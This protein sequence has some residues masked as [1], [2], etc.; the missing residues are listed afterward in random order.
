MPRTNF[1]RHNA[2][3]VTPVWPKDKI[4]KK[5]ENV[6]VS[7]IDY[8]PSLFLLS[9]LLAVQG[10]FVALVLATRMRSVTGPG[11]PALLGASAITLGVSIWGMHF[12]GMLALRMPAPAH[13]LPDPTLLSFVVAILAVA[14]AI[15]LV[16]NHP[17]SPAAFLL[18]AL[19]MG[20]GIV[21][22]HFI[23]MSALSAEFILSYSPV[24]VIASSV[25]GF[26]ASG[27][28]LHLALRTGSARRPPVI[29]AI[30]IGVAISG[31]HY[32]AMEGTMMTLCVPP[33]A[34]GAGLP[35]GDF[36]L[37]VSM[38]AIAISL[39]FLLALNPEGS[40]ETPASVPL[41]FSWA[42]AGSAALQG[43]LPATLFPVAAP[44]WAEPERNGVETVAHRAEEA[45]PAPLLGED[46]PPRRLPHALRA[47]RQ[48]RTVYVEVSTLC[49][50][51]ANGH[52]SML[53]SA[54]G[55]TLCQLSIS[56][57]EAK[58]DPK[59]FIRV[60]RSHL[61]ALDAVTSIERVGDGG[62]AWLAGAGKPVPVSRSR[63]PALR[64]S[65]AAWAEGQEG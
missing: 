29:P 65:L 21:G 18:G 55:E 9:I 58:L 13:Y 8:A 22:M 41:P 15:A 54:E 26:S 57:V 46:D 3:T 37:M 32:T 51:H 62:L 7:S 28:G 31:M 39:G 40:V 35:P 43:A 61:I 48:G 44:S 5:G 19:L 33:G 14:G 38:V 30:V 12:V 63:Y 27:L 52:Y 47:E 24:Y 59:R 17:L 25:I 45:T 2:G 20:G 1:F 4:K 64:E 10:A 6:V 49:A 36:G 11:R 60:H 23:G 53:A 16:A 42:P 56:A 34:H 50:V